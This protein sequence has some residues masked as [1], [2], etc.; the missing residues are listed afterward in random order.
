MEKRIR[1]WIWGSPCRVKFKVKL[2]E[3]RNSTQDHVIREFIFYFVMK[4]IYKL[5]YL[6]S[7]IG[8]KFGAAQY[9]HAGP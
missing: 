8:E 9:E 7:D 1:L 5:D 6:P 2:H 4:D 3:L